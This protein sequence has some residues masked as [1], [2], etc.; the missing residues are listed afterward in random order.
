MADGTKE[1][2][3]VAKDQKN[4]G[5]K[6]LTIIGIVLCVILVPILIMNVVLIVKGLINKDKVPTF[7]GRAPMIV[8]TDSMSPTI[9]AG[10]LIVV[11]TVDPSQVKEGDV[12]SFF[13]PA[14]SGS[15]VVTHRV[16]V[17]NDEVKA[18]LKLPSWHN[19]DNNPGIEG[20]GDN[21]IFHTQG[22]FNNTEDTD[23][24]P[25][26]KLVGVWTGT[27]LR[28]IGKVAM[29]LQTTPG[30]ILCIGVPILMLVAYSLIRRR[31]Y[32]RGKRADADELLKELEELK[33]ARQEQITGNAA[34]S[35][36]ESIQSQAQQTVSTAENE[37][38]KAQARAEE[39][40]AQLKALQEQL[41]Q[42]Q[43]T[44]AETAGTKTVETASDIADGQQG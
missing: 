24:V 38:A 43:K 14:S 8:L 6:A 3:K 23:P 34:D 13:D 31:M 35:S 30:L 15:S 44:Q 4:G 20:T 11:K 32:E 26:S 1:N 40:Q 33:K 9:N 18:Q 36:A 2:K 37:A 19:M 22:D 39:L 28:G 41:A 16:L 7:F 10:D 5:Y 42:A 29:F 17:S 21:I 27:N 12:I 25:A